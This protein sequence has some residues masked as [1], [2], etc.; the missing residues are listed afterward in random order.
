MAR[1]GRVCQ[2]ALS[3]SSKM[4]LWGPAP[5]SRAKAASRLAKSGL[6]TVSVRYYTVSPVVGPTKAVT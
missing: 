3:S 6:D 4:R 1:L 5:T 2:P